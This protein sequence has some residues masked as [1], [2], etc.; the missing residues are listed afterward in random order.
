MSY[1]SMTTNIYNIY[2]FLKIYYCLYCLYHNLFAYE[3]CWYIQYDIFYIYACEICCPETY[4]PHHYP[5]LSNTVP[6]VR[7]WELLGKRSLEGDNEI[8]VVGLYVYNEAKQ[9][10][11]TLTRVNTPPPHSPASS[12]W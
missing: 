1:M 4:L 2:S 5:I 10:V 8:P 6:V 3:V 11:V 9:C 7:P 12:Q